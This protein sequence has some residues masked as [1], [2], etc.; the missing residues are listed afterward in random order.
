MLRGTASLSQSTIFPYW[1]LFLTALPSCTPSTV[2]APVPVAAMERAQAVPE[3]SGQAAEAAPA[4]AAVV[5]GESDRPAAA[6]DQLEQRAREI[7]RLQ[8]EINELREREARLRASLR[9][10]LATL[11]SAEDGGPD[12]P[13]AGQALRQR[14]AE[15]QTA[16]ALA[17]A[18][19]ALAEERQRRQQ[20]E[21]ELARLKQ[22]TSTVPYAQDQ[23]AGT[24]LAA[25]RQEVAQLRAA[26]R[27]ER[28]AR[29]RLAEDFRVL[30]DRVAANATATDAPELRARLEQLEQEKQRIAESFN[31]SLAESQQRTAALERDLAL[32]RA[33]SA[34]T[35]G[36]GAPAT[37]VQAENSALRTQLT[38][39]QGRTE[40]LASKLRMAMRVADLIFKMQAQQGQP[41]P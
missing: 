9:R 6:E 37:S 18:R 41:Q 15:T 21:A 11:G 19:A 23:A 26:L 5:A 34:A 35:A 8:A 40:D 3:A 17:G 12:A 24:D 31:R 10:V 14:A 25:A 7:E 16:G 13:P 36:D 30:Q 22:E 39:E 28:A 38:E 4:A 20:V 29:E 33:A 27:D 2:N 1:L 32:A